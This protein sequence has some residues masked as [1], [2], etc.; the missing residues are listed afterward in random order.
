MPKYVYNF[1]EGNRDQKDLLGGKG[2]N[3]AEMTN[4]GIPGPP[5]FTV[6]TEACKHYLHHGAAP[7]ELDE[8]VTVALKQIEERTGKGF[9]DPSNPLLSRRPVRLVRS[10]AT[11][12][13]PVAAS[14]APGNGR[15][16][17]V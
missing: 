10:D 12:R 5:G 7:D 11:C 15:E 14:A 6:T 2:A 4:M 13:T 9:G 17:R 16:P 8:Q 3:L 1:T